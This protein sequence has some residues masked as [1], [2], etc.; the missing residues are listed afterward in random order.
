V[1]GFTGSLE[2]VAEGD[3]LLKSLPVGLAVEVATGAGLAPETG[4]VAA[5]VVVVVLAGGEGDLVGAKYKLVRI[6]I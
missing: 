1:A 6:S 4:L 5:V 2:A 3:Q